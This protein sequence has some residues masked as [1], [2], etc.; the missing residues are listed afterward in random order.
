M[1]VRFRTEADRQ[2]RF[3]ALPDRTVV[4]FATPFVLFGV[5]FFVQLL[6]ALGLL[7][8]SG[9]LHALGARLIGILVLGLSVLTFGLPGLAL[10]AGRRTVTIDR[11][12]GKL[13][14]CSG[15]ALL[16]HETRHSI[17]DARLIMLRYA[18]I[19]PGATR[20]AGERTHY[21]YHLDLVWATGKR[22]NLALHSDASL[23][24]EWGRQTA[25]LLQIEFRDTSLTDDLRAHGA[26]IA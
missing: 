1:T 26:V 23:L 21:A 13:V 19:M 25:D 11:V 9:T 4:L 18:E 24:R 20:R 15:A 8:L 10:V 5:Y 3:V 14:D 2:L 17:A 22:L 16:R 6:A 12:G 7:V